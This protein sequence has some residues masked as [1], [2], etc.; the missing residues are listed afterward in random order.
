MNERENENEHW[1]RTEVFSPVFGRG[2]HCTCMGRKK[3]K[4][5]KRTMTQY[6][7]QSAELM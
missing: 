6:D 2:L 1:K 7:K 3:A 4:V 5:Q